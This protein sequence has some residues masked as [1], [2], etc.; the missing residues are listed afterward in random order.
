MQN[1]KT[2]HKVVVDVYYTALE[3]WK[4]VLTLKFIIW[5]LTLPE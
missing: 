1:I 3:K 4:L 5:K 2:S